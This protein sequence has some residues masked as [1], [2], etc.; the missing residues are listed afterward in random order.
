MEKYNKGFKLSG[1]K[2]IAE[3]SQY[4]HNYYVDKDKNLLYSE[5]DDDDCSSWYFINGSIVTY[6]GESLGSSNNVSL[7]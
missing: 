1:L 3:I 6:L 2:H 5:S 4:N 7:K